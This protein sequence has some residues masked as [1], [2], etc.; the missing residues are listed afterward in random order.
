MGNQSLQD[1]FGHEFEFLEEPSEFLA[2]NFDHITFFTFSLR[3][4][5]Y[6]FFNSYLFAAPSTLNIERQLIREKMIELQCH[7]KGWI[8]P[9]ARA[10]LLRP[11]HA[12]METFQILRCD[13]PSIQINGKETLAPPEIRE[14]L[15]STINLA[16][17][18]SYCFIHMQIDPVCKRIG[19]MVP[20]EWNILKRDALGGPLLSSDP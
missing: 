7:L 9:D 5:L 14:K 8:P 19:E 12:Y 18:Q 15:A 11:E 16:S 17:K 1:L 6:I 10:Q 2:Y 4:H 20:G 3:G 13:P